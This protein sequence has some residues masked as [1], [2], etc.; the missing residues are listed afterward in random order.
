MAECFFCSKN[1]CKPKNQVTEISTQRIK[2][3]ISASKQ[4]NDSK[5]NDLEEQ[6]RLNPNL[7]ISSH[8]SC[9]STYT[10]KT[11]ISRA[12]QNLKRKGSSERSKSEPPSRRQ[13]SAQRSIP[14]F[15]FKTHCLICGSEC[16]PPDT[17][18]PK[19]WRK[20]SKCHD[21]KTKPGQKSLKKCL[22]D[23]CTERGDEKANEVRLRIT[24]GAPFDLHAVGAQYHADC[25]SSFMSHRNVFS[26]R[27]GNSDEQET[28]SAFLSVLEQMTNNKQR[29]W[30]SVELHEIYLQNNTSSAP[31]S[32]KWLVKKVLE[33][34]QNEIVEMRVAACASLFGFRQYLPYK[35]HKDDE[36]DTGETNKAVNKVVHK[37]QEEIENLSKE[38][39][40]YDLGRFVKSHAIE[41]TSSTLLALIT[42][43][44]SESEVTR[45][46][47]SIAQVIQSQ[48][49]NSPNATTLGLAVKLHHR[50]GSKEIVSLLHD[51]GFTAPYWEVLRFKD[52]AALYLCKQEETV[53]GSSLRQGGSPISAWFDNY[54]LQ[55]WTPNGRRETHSMA[56]EFTQ[57]SDDRQDSQNHQKNL[58]FPRLKHR[59]ARELA[60]GE[61]SSVA[62]EYYQGGKCPLPPFGAKD[63]G[64]ELPYIRTNLD[65]SIANA[66][67]SDVAWL[68]SVIANDSLEPEWSGYMTKLA[69]QSGTAI[70]GATN[71]A[72]GPLIDATPSHPDTV[73]T[74]LIFIERFCKKYG[75]S[76]VQLVADMQLYKVAVQIQWSDPLR[77][78]HV[79]IRPGG[80]HALM[81][82]IGCIGKLMQSS[83]LEEL[84]GAAYRGVANMLNGKA[85]PK[86]VRGLRM[87]VVYLLENAVQGSISVQSVEAV[88]TEARKWPTG[89]LWVDC[90]VSPIIIVH[91]FIRAEREGNWPLHIFCL[92]RMIPYFFAAAHWNYARYIQW[93]V[94]DMIKHSPNTGQFFSDGSH[95]CRHKDGVWNAV[96]SDQFGEQT[97]IRY[98]KSRGGLVGL[99]LSPD[100]V[101][102]WLLSYPVCN[103]VSAMMDEMFEDS[104]LG[105]KDVNTKHKEEGDNRKKEDSEDRQRIQN[106]LQKHANPLHPE[107]RTD[108]L[109]NIVNGCVADSKVNVHEALSIGDAMAFKFKQSLP[110]SFYKPLKNG[111]VTMESMKKGVKVGEHHVYDAEKLYGRLLVLSQSRKIQLESI[112]SFELAPVPSSLFDEYGNLRKTSK[113]MLIKKLG[114]TCDDRTDVQVQLIDGNEMLYNISWPRS[115][116]TRQL[117]YNFLNAVKKPAHD[118]YVI[119]DKYHKNSIKT[120]ERNRR[121]GQYIYPDRN[122]TINTPLPNRDAIMKNT[123][124]KKKVIKL[125]CENN[126]EYPHVRMVSQASCPFGH[127]EA[128]VSIIRYIFLLLQMNIKIMQVLA[129]DNDIFVLLIFFIWKWK[130]DIQVTMKK[131]DGTVIDINKSASNLGRSANRLLALH[132]LTGCDSTSYPYRKGKVTA[133]KQLKSDESKDL[134]CFGEI[135]TDKKDLIAAGRRFFCRLYGQK[136]TTTMNKLRYKLFA[137]KKSTPKV[138]TLPPTDEALEAHIL[139]AHLQVMIWKS[140]D[141][142]HP[143]AVDIN[144]FGWTIVDGLPEPVVGVDEVAPAFLLSVVAC[145]C[146]SDKPC[147]RGNC[148]CRS[149]GVSCTQ[150]CRCFDHGDGEE[151]CFNPHTSQRTTSTE[152]TPHLQDSDDSEFEG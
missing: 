72:F 74:A 136:Q 132:A 13:R 137:G 79:V 70:G 130:A 30:S 68:R 48:V 60:L 5:H 134:E 32:R 88:L 73:L 54:D 61:L 23:K 87:V 97:Y 106:E 31:L 148:S 62:M 76:G 69:R 22:L 125:L 146:A 28:D 19:R 18:N 152:H 101:S 20:V 90:L 71:F 56:I 115:G 92:E 67:E 9:V 108:K 42:K 135:S 150:Y 57:P 34:F 144:K 15:N 107:N 65:E 151:T 86:A 16:L 128:D 44:V 85:W 25:Y 21:V 149:S 100:Q 84:L 131:T 4:R 24:V 43:L 3:I 49:T 66:L 117:C 8:R 129:D 102:R 103:K 12:V 89:K 51:Y 39:H 141:R 140:A 142:N 113:A 122:I 59:E 27:R 10:S 77:W 147:S 111:V 63:V 38:S 82:F 45:T 47:L 2:S 46:T 94:M 116:T 112:F 17:K 80:M 29:V 83:G 81:S 37:I 52:S 118:V 123:E 145:S 138:K 55:V 33:H 105:K 75:Q 121:T 14:K 98:G 114:F 139:R 104:N 143:P 133:L 119:F 91:L 95:V 110:D 109:V 50:F 53:Y 1:G 120:H 35:L 93:H 26:A 7:T 11:H 127:E 99:T 58:T 124:N 36:D 126:T 78:K 6:L 96:F 40:E 41:N 64:L